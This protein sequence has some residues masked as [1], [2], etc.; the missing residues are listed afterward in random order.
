VEQVEIAAGNHLSSLHFPIFLG[1][2]YRF[3]TFKAMELAAW[4]DESGV[5]VMQRIAQTQFVQN[6]PRNFSKQGDNFW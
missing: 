6:F 5:N 4:I 1:N 2:R 3:V